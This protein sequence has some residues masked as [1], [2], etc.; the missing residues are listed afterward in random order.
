MPETALDSYA[1]RPRGP[2]APVLAGV[3]VVSALANLLAS[4]PRVLPSAAPLRQWLP[5]EVTSGSRLLS[6]MAGLFLLVLARGLA[7]R[8]HAAWQFAV[9]LFLLSAASHPFKG[10]SEEVALLS[11]LMAGLLLALRRE[12]WV[13]S[14]PLTLASGW[15]VM[16]LSLVL[17]YGYTV[18]GYYLLRR[19]FAEVTDLG[20]AAAAALGLLTSFQTGD[21][22]PLNREAAAFAGSACALEAM[23]LF[24]GLLLLLAPFIDRR[25]Q[26][27]ER[28][29]VEPLLRRLGRSSPSYFALEGHTRYYFLR[30]VAGVVPYTYRSG[31]ALVAGE[32]LCAAGDLAAAA[33]EFDAYCREHDWTPAFYQVGPEARAAL[34]GEGFAALQIGEE[35]YFEL[36][37]Y[38]LE[39]ARRARLRHG[40]RRAAREGVVV[41]EH[42]P[43]LPG[44]E[45][46]Q[47]RM[48][49]LSARWLHEHGGREMGYLLGGLSFRAPRDRRYFVAEWEGR[50]MGVVTFVPV[51][52]TRGMVLDVLRRAS[53]APPGTMEAVIHHALQVFAAE[54]V[55]RAS[56]ALAPLAQAAPAGGAE[57]AGAERVLR[58]AFERL[59]RFYNFRT[60]FAFKRH[61]GPDAWEPRYLAYRSAGALP[62]IA[63]ALLRA[64]DPRSLL[65]RWR[66]GG[67]RR[68]VSAAGPEPPAPEAA[69]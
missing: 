69:A 13:K 14:D 31:A 59:N 23:G 37:G 4:L 40:V 53:E 3:T 21:A 61:L 44:A 20:A 42:V 9:A 65:A 19:H 58:L 62:A 15:A 49:E 56:V 2:V 63:L 33:R 27:A 39:G 54:G 45:R 57:G 26:E 55:P 7:R 24:A 11:L 50:A 34:A 41:T 38:S 43:G 67:P 51:Y 8:K 60:L 30:G 47:A 36:P 35:G 5:L 52:A 10:K 12:F 48:E 64:H 29:Q 66:R 46:R 22:F 28:S 32:P 68:G 17:S 25:R 1:A 18:A 16:G 6:A